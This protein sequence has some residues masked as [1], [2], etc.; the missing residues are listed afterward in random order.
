MERALTERSR[1]VQLAHVGHSRSVLK[2]H[3]RTPVLVGE[4]RVTPRRH[5]ALR[6][7]DVDLALTGNP[8][9]E[10]VDDLVLE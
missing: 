1:R 6:A 4:V 3:A 2:P 10:A 9:T 7:D 5:A 8:R